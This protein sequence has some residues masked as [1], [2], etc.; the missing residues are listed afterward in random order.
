VP[1]TRVPPVTPRR[2]G[3]CEVLVTMLPSLVNAACG[4]G[5][6]LPTE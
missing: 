6:I 4:A 5:C 3:R 2:I 1:H